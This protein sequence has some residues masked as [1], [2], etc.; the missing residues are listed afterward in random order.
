MRRFGRCVRR[1][2]RPEAVDGRAH[3]RRLLVELV[4]PEVV[5]V[6]RRHPGEAVVHGVEGCPGGIVVL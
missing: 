5:V 3:P 1:A 2:Q 4:A 6:G